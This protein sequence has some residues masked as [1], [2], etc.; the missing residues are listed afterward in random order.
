MPSSAPSQAYR[1]PKSRTRKLEVHM[2]GYRVNQELRRFLVSL[3]VN[4]YNRHLCRRFPAH[5]LYPRFCRAG[6]SRFVSVAQRAPV[7]HLSE[8]SEWAVAVIG[9][10]LMARC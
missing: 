1:P 3:S 8:P 6:W 5:S 7:E 9:P 4:L 10:V 2:D